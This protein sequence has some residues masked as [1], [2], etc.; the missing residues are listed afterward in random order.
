MTGNWTR[1]D[2]EQ[3]TKGAEDHGGENIDFNQ[4]LAASE[5]GAQ[6]YLPVPRRR[7]SDKELG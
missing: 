5:V 7:E 1:L 2:S 3:L 6:G 4:G